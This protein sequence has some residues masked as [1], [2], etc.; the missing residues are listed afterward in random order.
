MILPVE[1]VTNVTKFSK[2]LSVWLNFTAALDWW[3]TRMLGTDTVPNL[4]NKLKC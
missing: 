2:V 1:F 3:K 4:A